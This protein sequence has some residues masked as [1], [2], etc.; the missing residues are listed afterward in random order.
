MQ[1]VEVRLQNTNKLESFLS[2]IKLKVSDM[3]VVEIDGSEVFGEVV[4][5]RE[6]QSDKKIKNKLLKLRNYLKRHMTRLNP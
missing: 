4:F 6:T 2:D 1:R 5:V 3:I